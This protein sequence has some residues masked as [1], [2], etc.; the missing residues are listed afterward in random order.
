MCDNKGISSSS[1]KLF[2]EVICKVW[3]NWFLILNADTQKSNFYKYLASLPVYDFG[4]VSLPW[5]TP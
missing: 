3:Y 5:F 4:S 1:L 2:A